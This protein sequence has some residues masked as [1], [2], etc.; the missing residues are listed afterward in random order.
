MVLTPHDAYGYA[1]VD[2]IVKRYVAA[3]PVATTENDAVPNG[4]ASNEAQAPGT[5]SEPLPQTTM[6]DVVPTMTRSFI[7]V[8]F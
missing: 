8:L 6:G 5:T 2:S 4:T 7:V 1:V 3:E